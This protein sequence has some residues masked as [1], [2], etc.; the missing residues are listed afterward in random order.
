[1]VTQM[2]SRIIVLY[3]GETV[4][5]EGVTVTAKERPDMPR[6]PVPVEPS[7]PIVPVEPIQRGTPLEDYVKKALPSMPDPL[8]VW[9]G[10]RPWNPYD[11]VCEG[12]K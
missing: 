11:I 2:S 8:P 1:M 12:G 9:P 10:V 4:T 7:K 6:T 5:L 3:P